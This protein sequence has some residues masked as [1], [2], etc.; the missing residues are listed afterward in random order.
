MEFLSNTYLMD[1]DGDFSAH[2]SM[3]AGVVAAV[4]NNAEGISGVSPVVSLLPVQGP[5][6]QGA[7]LGFR[8]GGRDALRGQPGADITCHSYAGSGKSAVE[9]A[10]VKALETARGSHGGGCRGNAGGESGFPPALP[11][12]LYLPRHPCRSDGCA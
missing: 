1:F 3:V 6:W 2:G 9:E 5:R 11:C 10:A 7:G 4:G 8:C 12:L